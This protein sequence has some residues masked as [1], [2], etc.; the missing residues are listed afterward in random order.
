MADSHNNVDNEMLIST[1][2]RQFRGYR[3]NLERLIGAAG[4]ETLRLDDEKFAK[5]KPH[6][7]VRILGEYAST[8][9]R[10]YLSEFKVAA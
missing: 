7:I 10:N 8:Q 4:L 3:M 9:E 2:D 6:E 5:R 1:F